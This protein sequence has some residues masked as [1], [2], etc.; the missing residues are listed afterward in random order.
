MDNSAQ[1]HTQHSP[2]RSC[3]PPSP[4]KS[5]WDTAKA[6]LSPQ[7][8]TAQQDTARTRP[9]SRPA[10]RSSPQHS[11]SST[12]RRTARSPATDPLSRSTAPH[13]KASAAPT[14][15]G[16]T[17]PQ[18]TRPRI[19]HTASRCTPLAHRTSSH[20]PPLTPRCSR[21]HRC[22]ARSAP[23]DPSQRSTSLPDKAGTAI[24]WPAPSRC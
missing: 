3:C 5:P 4:R 17:S 22:T 16:S 23:Q 1:Q 6:P 8:S 7:G 12:L 10:A 15:E 9:H 11:R 18:D 24:C 14:P 21:S 2:T 19:L 20:S 13:R